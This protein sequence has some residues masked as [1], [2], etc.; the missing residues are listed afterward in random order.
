MDIDNHTESALSRQLITDVTHHAPSSVKR[1]RRG[2]FF[3]LQGFLRW[4]LKNETLRHFTV[5]FLQVS[6]IFFGKALNHGIRW[7]SFFNDDSDF[8]IIE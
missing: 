4:V 7:R 8:R 6:F 5:K 2:C 3:R 1:E